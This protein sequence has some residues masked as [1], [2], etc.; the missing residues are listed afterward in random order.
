MNAHRHSFVQVPTII[1][2][3][4]PA[5]QQ[6]VYGFNM[7]TPTPVFSDNPLQRL[8]PSAKSTPRVGL[9]TACG[10]STLNISY[11]LRSVKYFLT[12]AVVCLPLPST[13][14]HALAARTRLRQLEYLPESEDV[15]VEGVALAQRFTLA[16]K[17]TSFV[18]IDKPKRTQT[19]E[20]QWTQVRPTL[21][22]SFPRAAPQHNAHVQGI[23]KMQLAFRC[24]KQPRSVPSD[25]P[26]F[27]VLRT[28][29]Q[30]LW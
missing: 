18:A 20:P 29:F 3:I 1:P 30:L 11:E 22:P 7:Q 5:T 10:Q 6:V 24:L 21:S 14:I 8:F 4:F 27:I 9:E 12:V 15:K 19:V 2:P 25:W 13:H 16:S 28:H 23:A 17:W 26:V